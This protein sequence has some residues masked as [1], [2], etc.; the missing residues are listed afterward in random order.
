MPPSARQIWLALGGEI[1]GSE[2]L[3]PQPLSSFAV[4]SRQV[5]PGGM[6]VAL[7]GTRTEG[8]LFME[9]ARRHGATTI[10]TYAD[11]PELP[12]SR[13]QL[14]KPLP[15]GALAR[16]YIFLVED[17][18]AA[19]QKLAAFW[20]RQFELRVVAITGSV[21]K[22]TTKE[23]TAAVLRQ[24]FRV[25]KSEQN[26]NNEIGL[27]LTL[28]QLAEEHQVA[29]LEMGTYGP[30][31]I[32]SLAAMASPQVGI[33][34]NVGPTHLERMGSLDRIAAA[35]AELVRALP[36]NGL[37]ILNGDDPLVAAMAAQSAAPVMTYGLAAENDLWADEIASAGLEGIRFTF[38]Y[39]DEVIPVRIPLLG[40]HSVHTALRSAAVGL[41]YGLD[42]G[43]IAA[44]LQD[45][46]AQLRLVAVPGIG[47]STIIDD[48]YNASPASV[49]AALNLL[50]ELDGRHIAVLGDMLE[51]GDYEEKGHRLVGARAAAVTQL[52]VAVGQRARWIAEEAMAQGMPEDRVVLLNAAMEAS[53]FLRE[54]LRPGDVLLVKGSRA[55]ALERVVDDLSGVEAY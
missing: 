43:E 23:L 45:T 42:W 4:D 5:E 27:P 10:L 51:L 34:T 6:F 12:G 25:L 48:T 40:Q 37:A 1:V 54:R 55:M 38:H 32:T 7:P 30:G 15:I 19:L 50:A 14:D 52:L 31:E 41:S 17:S 3:N 2:R 46:T 47:G 35:K 39:Q 16:P 11:L 49:L 26:Y 53:E 36:A 20:R 22:T 21:G 9:D 13:L 28:L 44:G 24:R 29:V 33:V 8:Y 18:L